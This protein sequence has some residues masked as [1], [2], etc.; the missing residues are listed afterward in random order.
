MACKALTHLNVTWCG[1][2]LR[3]DW[4]D[5]GEGPRYGYICEI[6]AAS[7]DEVDEVEDALDLLFLGNGGLGD[8]VTYID[9]Y[10]ER[11]EDQVV[12][13]SWAE[14]QQWQQRGQQQPPQEQQQ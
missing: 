4:F 2:I 13:A 14:L 7:S 1:G 10:V 8:G 6:D 12:F 5:D 11:V 9:K 3:L